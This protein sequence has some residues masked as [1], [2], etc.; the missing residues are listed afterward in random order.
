MGILC[1]SEINNISL[2]SKQI[3]D[4]DKILSQS[5]L[6][7]S[8][9]ESR[10]LELKA[11]IERYKE[12]IERPLNIGVIGSAN[13]VKTEFVNNLLS[14]NGEWKLPQNNIN[15]EICC[16]FSGKHDTVETY[17]TDDENR[18]QD[19]D[20]SILQSDD[21][22]ILQNAK[23]IEIT[24]PAENDLT[25]LFS[26]KII[27]ITVYPDENSFEQLKN[28]DL[29]IILIKAEEYANYSRLLS[30]IVNNENI[31]AP[32]I[33][34]FTQTEKSDNRAEID[35]CYQE[36]ENVFFV[37]TEFQGETSNIAKLIAF[38][39]NPDRNAI[40]NNAIHIEQHRIGLINGQQNVLKQKLSNLKKDIEKTLSDKNI[41]K[42][43]TVINSHDSQNI[44]DYL[45]TKLDNQ[46][47]KYIAEV[48]NM[49]LAINN[50]Y[51]MSQI[52]AIEKSM[53]DIYNYDHHIDNAKKFYAMFQDQ[54]K[55]L[56]VQEIKNKT[57]NTEYREHLVD[58]TESAF[59]SYQDID[60]EEI[61][62]PIG[63][64][65][66]SQILDNKK[67]NHYIKLTFKNL[68]SIIT[69][70]NVLIAIVIGIAVISLLL[71][72]VVGDPW[73]IKDSWKETICRYAMYAIIVLSILV[74]LAI[75]VATKNN[76]KIEFSKYKSQ[77]IN[78]LNSLKQPFP[79][80]EIVDD[81]KS[82]NN[83]VVAEISEVENSY[84]SERRRAERQKEQIIELTGN[85]L[86]NI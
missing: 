11:E 29:A 57:E 17:I 25:L 16:L 33:I 2:L 27:S 64:D 30:Y 7:D 5:P 85:M 42:I 66:S 83:S 14:F 86:N 20:S 59:V 78:D 75:W 12:L 40:G 8:G 45:L 24:F 69:S 13:S 44:Q 63:A 74:L 67:I 79:K 23:K 1:L 10:L 49:I 70:P 21:N 9:V 80:N 82:Y 35:N 36:F 38:Y 37:N 61:Y 18:R 48:D 50:A 56:V 28:L 3:E 77:V 54:L 84:R 55:D 53:K 81:L 43:K 51:N 39:V 71:W 68:I 15:A 22:E 32:I 73:F 31:I 26:K 60:F 19:V 76:K 72:I 46:Y 6:E 65:M 52:D 58:A 47:G 41:F 62:K 34:V 4:I